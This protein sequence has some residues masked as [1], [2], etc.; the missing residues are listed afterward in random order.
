MIRVWYYLALAIVFSMTLS[1][2]TLQNYI[3]LTTGESQNTLDLEKIKYQQLVDGTPSLFKVQE[4]EKIEAKIVSQDGKHILKVGPFTSGDGLALGYMAVR[5]SFPYAFILEDPSVNQGV[6]PKIQYIDREVFVEKEDET[7]WTALFGLAIIGILSLFLSS[8]QLKNLNLKHRRIQDRQAEIEEKQSLLLEKMGEKIQKVALK[9]VDDEKKLLET[10]LEHI[11]KTEI[12]NQIVNLKKYDEELLRTTY[13]LIDFLKIKSGNIIIKEEAFQLSNMLH[14]LTNAV[15]PAL[16]KRE[17]TLVY[18]IQSDVTRYLVG[19]SSRIYQI[20]HNL[21][22]DVFESQE[23]SEVVL[24]IEVREEETLVFRIVNR[25]QFLTDEEK[26]R[27]FIPNTWEEIQNTNKDFGYFVINEL[28]S[29]M[30]GNFLIQSD[31]KEGTLYELSLPYVRDVDNQSQ[32]DKLSKLLLNKKALIVDTDEKKAETLTKILNSFSIETVFKSSSHLAK[33]RPNMEGIDFIIIKSEDVS[34]KVFNFFNEI[35]NNDDLD[36]IVIN[37]IFESN[38]AVDMVSRI[39]DAELFSPLIIGDVEEVLRQLCIK[40][41]K[42]TKDFIKEELRNF[43]ILNHAKVTRTDFEKFTNKNIL[44][45][46]DNIVSQQVLSSILSASSMSVHKVENGLQALEFLEKNPN[47]DL[48]FMDMDMPVINGFEATREIRKLYPE[49][50]IPIVA[51]TGLGFNYEMEQMI[52]S[53][54]DACI[55]KPFKV[56]QLYVAL[57]RFLK[58]EGVTPVV[59]EAKE[60]LYEEKKAILDVQKGISYV[61]NDDFY[62]EIVMQ[63]SLAL[64][65]SDKLVRDMIQNDQIEELRVFCIDAVGLSGTI[66]ATSFVDLLNKML[67]RMNDEKEFIARYKEEWLK[68]LLHMNEETVFMS[69]F[70]AGYKEE[71]LKLEEEI[72]RYLM[73]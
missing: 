52:L 25:N 7:L 47:V 13:E 30:H 72:K 37:N 18:D 70:I 51:V 5:S 26:E 14:K 15:A 31:K 50:K 40:K 19:D 53:G 62:K 16:K 21:I 22:V 73:R 11:N 9:S 24:H 63:V 55:T 54:V 68:M 45:V 28:I 3:V 48:I 20:L 65:N 71:W 4:N 2:Q 64:R 38:N 29:N 6:S 61:H 44:I 67:L 39:A 43:R 27:L 32:K 34:K 59:V 23:M 33:H 66:G 10:S 8:D 35:T 58:Q 12:K 49:N 56:G 42:K 69:E 57:Q 17:H 46:E 60:A 36:I 41:D 1:A